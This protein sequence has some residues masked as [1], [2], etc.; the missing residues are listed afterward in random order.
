MYS[1]YRSQNC[2]TPKM[3]S[4]FYLFILFTG[5]TMHHP[6][7]MQHDSNYARMSHGKV[8]GLKAVP[9]TCSKLVIAP[10]IQSQNSSL[11]AN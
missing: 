10:I 9:G 7:F 4:L 11:M 2:V 1:F 8:K 6:D 3:E 5:F